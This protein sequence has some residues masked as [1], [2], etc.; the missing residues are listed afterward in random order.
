MYPSRQEMPPAFRPAVERGE[1]PPEVLL[2]SV[3]VR[4]CGASCLPSF[5]LLL[6][7]RPPRKAP[8]AFEAQPCVVA[9]GW[10]H[11]Y[12]EAAGTGGLNQ[13]SQTLGLAAPHPYTQEIRPPGLGEARQAP[14][15]L[16]ITGPLRHMPTHSPPAV[17]PAPG[18]Q[19]PRLGPK[20]P[21]AV[22]PWKMCLDLS[23]QGLI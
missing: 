19:L 14:F 22:V 18:A 20:R 13:H 17:I 23:S 11:R 6:A 21:N 15:S 5:A 8:S 12:L 4:K 10:V 7:L 16:L 3:R 9:S 2:S 1:E